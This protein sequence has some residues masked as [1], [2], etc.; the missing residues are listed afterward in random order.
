MSLLQRPRI[1]GGES[2]TDNKE[3][4]WVVNLSIG[5]VAQAA[6][7]TDRSTISHCGGTIITDRFILT[8][9]I[10]CYGSQTA[11]INTYTGS[12]NFFEGELYQ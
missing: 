5:K 1:V 11:E 6:M 3:W 9:G 8:A 2:V 7:K 4:P 10:C 12:N